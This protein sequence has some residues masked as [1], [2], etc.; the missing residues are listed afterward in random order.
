M[1]RAVANDRTAEAMRHAYFGMEDQICGI[2]LMADLVSLAVDQFDPATGDGW[3]KLLFAITEHQR[4]IERLKAAY[5]A[6]LSPP[7]AAATA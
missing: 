1:S 7:E 6:A 4:M 5:Y 2:S 3:E